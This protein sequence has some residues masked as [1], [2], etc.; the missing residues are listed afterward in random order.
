MPSPSAF[1]RHLKNC[2]IVDQLLGSVF[3][4]RL[5]ALYWYDMPLADAV[6]W[7]GIGKVFRHATGRGDKDSVFSNYELDSLYY[8]DT[9]ESLPTDHP[10]SVWNCLALADRAYYP[11]DDH[12]GNALRDAAA[13][14]Q[15]EFEQVAVEIE[16]HPDSNDFASTGRWTG[17]FLSGT[18]GEIDTALA[19]RCPRTTEVLSDLPVCRNFGFV[20]FS[21]IEPHTTI[22]AHHGSSNLRL[23]YHLGIRVPEPDKGRIRVG[24]EWHQWREGEVMAFDDSYEHEVVYEGSAPRI[25]LIVDAWHPD[26]H[27][28]DIQVLSHPVFG[29]FGK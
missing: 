7:P 16:T 12:I 22:R 9:R 1:G 19:Q 13:D 28:E 10:A 2:R 29:A 11:A 26:L 14:I 20:A 21:G 8:A 27:E 18:Q 24:D 25:V 4:E 5:D 6:S 3:S 23:R 17:L 15:A